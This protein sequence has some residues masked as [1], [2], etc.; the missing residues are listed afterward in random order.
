MLPSNVVVRL[1][2]EHEVLGLT[3]MLGSERRT[4]YFRVETVEGP[5]D[6]GNFS[7]GAASA[8]AV[9]GTGWSEIQDSANRW[10]LEPEYENIAYHFFFG[11]SP[12]QA[13][14]YR[15]YPAG[16]EQNS[17]VGTRAIGD[18]VGYVDGI[19]SPA[20]TPSSL[21]EMFTVRG[22]RPSFFGYH[23]YLE[24]TSI[25]VRLN[26]FVTRYDMLLLGTDPSGTDVDK[27]RK[28][29]P[30]EIRRAARVRAIGGHQLVPMPTWIQSGLRK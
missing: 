25:T 12:G 11:V 1:L 29:A 30:E 26:F 24:P 2:R 19:K 15:A 5:N 20:H 21:T 17:L 9:A 7:L 18:A 8:Q 27:A 6:L 22:T 4:A 16:R 14:I 28:I 10:L 13:W 23:P 3:M